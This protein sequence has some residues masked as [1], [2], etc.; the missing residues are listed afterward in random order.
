MWT[1]DEGPTT[2]KG[3][4]TRDRIV[5]AAAQ[6]FYRQGVARTSMPDVRSAAAVSSSQIYHYFKD[7]DALTMAV[8]AYQSDA[9]V[10]AQAD[11]LDNVHDLDG[12]R[13]WRDFVVTSKRSQSEGGCPVGGLASELANTDP[14][15]RKALA[16]GFD[17][18]TIALRRG[19]ERMVDNGV[20]AEDCNPE[21]LA[22]ALLAV[23]Q[24]GLLIAQAEHSTASLEAGLDAVIDSIAGHARGG[25]A[26]SSPPSRSMGS[27]RAR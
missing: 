15:A 17:Q 18:W 19:L 26:D 4:A 20:L 8:V 25:P 22:R 1:I 6:L 12:L 13:A 5:A 10:H 23:L 9:I 3:R 16:E 24:G 7:K 21:A 14:D 11:Y 27:A 2:A